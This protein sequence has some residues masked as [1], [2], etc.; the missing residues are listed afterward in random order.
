MV[1]A[2]S[3]RRRHYARLLRATRPNRPSQNRTQGAEDRACVG[4]AARG[5]CAR[6]SLVFEHEGVRRFPRRSLDSSPFRRRSGQSSGNSSCEWW[7]GCTPAGVTLKSWPLT[8][9]G[10]RRGTKVEMRRCH[11]HHFGVLGCKRPAQSGNFGEA[12]TPA[13][14]TEANRPCGNAPTRLASDPIALIRRRIRA[15]RAKVRAMLSRMRLRPWNGLK[16]RPMS[17][18]AK[19]RHDVRHDAHAAVVDFFA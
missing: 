12:A 7:Y 16:I 13:A 6:T 15:H 10:R 11:A 8:N 17:C 1:D 14:L 3:A 4:A 9:S 19:A 18:K 2:A 5:C